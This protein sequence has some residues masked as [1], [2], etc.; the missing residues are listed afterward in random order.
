MNN[1]SFWFPASYEESRER[2]HQNLARVQALWPSAQLHQH[3]LA[4]DED[5]T[6]DWISAE[7]V[8]HT[9]KILVI[10]TAEHGIEGYVGSAILSYFFEHFLDRLT[11]KNTDLLLVHTIN[12]WGMKNLRRTNANNVDLN[13]NFVWIPDEIDPAFNLE[14]N[15]LTSFLTPARPVP[16]RLIAQLRFNLHLWI[17]IIKMGFTSLRAISSLGHYHQPK[18]I[19]YGGDQIQEETRVMMDLYRQVFQQSDQILH[20]DMHTGW[21]PRDQMSLVN[22]YLEKRGSKE[23]TEYFSYPQIVATIPGEFYSMRGDMIDY[24]YTLREKKFPNTKLFAT[25]FEF[26]TLG[27][28]IIAEIRGLRAMILENQNF[29]FGTRGV[30]TKKWVAREFQ[31]MFYPQEKKWAAKAFADADQAFENILQVEKYL[32]VH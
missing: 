24:V 4:G 21:G 18:G 32:R 20:L 15:Q 8:A 26:G 3:C 16:T 2:F 12:P 22:S 29:W 10:T 7:A 19:H 9:E 25:S 13:R 1:K 5:L 11:P 30:R 28:S 6:I 14:L 27:D 17:M 23:L 31:E